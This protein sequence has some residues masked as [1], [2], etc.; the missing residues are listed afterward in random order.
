MSVRV[1]RKHGIL[2]IELN[3]PERLNGFTDAL[4]GELLQALQSVETD[5]EI[6]VVV[7]TGAGRSFSCGMDL[8]DLARDGVDAIDLKDKLNRLYNPIALAMQS[9]RAPILCGLQGVAAGGGASLVLSAD[10]IIATTTSRLVSAFSRIGL[11]PDCGGSWSMV[12]KLGYA[13]ALS[14]TLLEQEI[15][16]QEALRTGL[17]L[18]LVENEDALTQAL[19]TT[20]EKLAEASP[21]AVGATRNLLRQ[22]QENTLAAQLDAET[23]AQVDAAS[24]NDFR[25]GITAF[26]EKRVPKF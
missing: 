20:A 17:V 3:R 7:L 5:K 1:S 19:K 16:A 21:T 26:F 24:Q 15:D 22:S 4:A 8:N 18:Q 25:E 9:C 2:S 10:F 13:R 6:R 12:R 23:A 14:F 11:V